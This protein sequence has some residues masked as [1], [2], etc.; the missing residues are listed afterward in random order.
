MHREHAALELRVY[1]VEISIVGQGE[2]AHE[3]AVAAFDT[4]IFPFLFFLLKLPFAGDGQH[5]GIAP[6]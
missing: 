4:V 6:A 1:F 3:R 2:A 5:A